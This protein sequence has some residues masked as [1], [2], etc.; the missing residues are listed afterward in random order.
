M[1]NLTR[2][3][4]WYSHAKYFFVT[5]VL[6]ILCIPN[7]HHSDIRLGRVRRTQSAY[8]ILNT[9]YTLSLI[10][11]N[12][13]TLM[14]WNL[15]LCRRVIY[16]RVLNSWEE[17]FPESAIIQYTDLDWTPDNC[18][19]YFK[20]ISMKYLRTINRSKRVLYFLETITSPRDNFFKVH[21]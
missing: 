5:H 20:S 1:A 10:N 6:T 21:S 19:D 2:P 16:R 17:S 3:K 12:L 14:G 7:T 18:I 11:F 13:R 8:D 9:W 4:L 15:P